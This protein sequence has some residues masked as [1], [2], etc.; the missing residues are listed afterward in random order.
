[1]SECIDDC[2]RPKPVVPSHPSP[3]RYGATSVQGA[4]ALQE[5]YGVCV[6][7][8]AG[9]RRARDGQSLD[10]GR[11][12]AGGEGGDTVRGDLCTD[13]TGISISTSLLT[14]ALG[15]LCRLIGAITSTNHRLSLIRLVI[16]SRPLN[17]PEKVM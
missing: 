8:V 6:G 17:F 9:G 7:C 16:Y 15:G 14:P 3:H 12:P 13:F 1:L 10:G 2:G 11:R 4:A 5:L